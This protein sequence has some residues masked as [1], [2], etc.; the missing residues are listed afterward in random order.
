MSGGFHKNVEKLNLSINGG[1]LKRLALISMLID[2]AGAVIVQRFMGMPEFNYEF[3]HKLY[4]PMRLM[5]RVAFPIYCYLLVQGFIHT[6]NKG[7]YFLRICVFALISE[8][9]FNLAITGN[10]FHS[11][12]QNVFCELAL[13]M[14]MLFFLEIVEKKTEALFL[15]GI[16]IFTIVCLA[17]CLGEIFNFDYGYYGIFSIFIL[18]FCRGNKRTQLVSGA[19]SFLWEW[20]AI[21][22][23]LPLALYNGKRGRQ[24]KYA[25]YIIYPLHLIIYYYIA[26]LAGSTI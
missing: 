7:K 5:G 11:G 8:I 2:H 23:F 16:E 24:M 6:K 3:W 9:P 17:M 15:K 10:L 14:L 19:L 1:Q 26:I 21:F 18:Y 12:Y 4:E 22:A 25:F 20:P 13:G